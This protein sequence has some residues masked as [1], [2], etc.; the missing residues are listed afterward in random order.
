LRDSYPNS[1]FL[2]MGDWNGRTGTKQVDLPHL[3]DLIDNWVTNPEVEETRDVRAEG[4]ENSFK[5]FVGLNLNNFYK[6]S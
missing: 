3:Y 4:E 5:M 1:E 2:I 6:K